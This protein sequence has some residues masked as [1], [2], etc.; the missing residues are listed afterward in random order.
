MS[1]RAL[2]TGTVTFLF[3]DIEGSTR[4]L[5][6][7]GD[8]YRGVQ[9]HHAEIL[10]RAI[11][12]GDGYEVRTEGDAFFVAF[13]NAA[14][15]VR[16]AVA[17][18]RELA[19]HPWPEGVE[20]RV[21]AGLHTG[22]GRL[23][24]DDYIGLDVNRAARIA[25]V[26]HGGQA[27]LSG[28]THALVEHDLPDGV[29]VRDVGRHRLKDLA[30]PEH[31]YELVIEGL[32]SD[33]PPPRSLEARP[34]NL[35][36]QLTSFVGRQREI[37]DVTDRLRRTKLLTLSGP[38]GVG[39]TR[40]ALQVAGEILLE[41]ADGARFVDLSPVTDAA[42][43][44]RAIASAL[45]I[46]EE[47]GRPLADTL[48]DH[49]ADKEM[50]LV[51]DNFE[52]V[53][54]AAGA[55]GDL[56]AAAPRCTFLVTSRAP[57]QL[58]GEQ[59]VSVEPL[60]LPDPARSPDITNLGSESVA[61]FA[62]RSALADPRLRLDAA[63]TLIVGEICS[64]LDGLP[65]AIELAASRVKLLSLEEI[66]E[67]LGT[68]LP[69]LTTAVRD[70]PER[71]RALRTTIDWSYEL[72]AAPER[73]L[74]A[75][76]S[77]FAGG[78]TIESADAVANPSGELGLATLD[79]LSSLVDK[80]LVR[81]SE[82]AG[83]S[84]FGM[85]ETIREYATERLA[86][87]GR[88][89]DVA[90][91]HADYFAELS[92]RAEPEFVGEEQ[93][94]WLDRFEREHENIRAALGWCL[95]SG[96]TEPGLRIAAAIW[97]FWQ[98]RGHLIEGRQWV[99]GLLSL[100]SAAD[101]TLTRGRAVSAAGSLA[102]WQ[103]D[104]PEAERLYQESLTVARTSGDATAVFDASFNLA[105]IPW[106]RGD[107]DESWSLLQ[108][109]LVIARELG[110]ERRIADTASGLAYA[111]FMREDYETALSLNEE[112]IALAREAGNRFILAENIETEGQVHRMLG[113]HERSRAAYLE[114]LELKHEAGNLPGIIT[115]L[116][117]LSVLESGLG[118]HERAVRLFGAASAMRE[119]FA[120]SPPAL[121]LDD[122]RAAARAAIGA[123]AT[124]RAMD[125]GRSMDP[126]AAVACANEP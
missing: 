45:A 37:A 39:K 27:L 2:P 61:L 111:A 18:Q 56:L 73:E 14:G 13:D 59:E 28:P 86:D 110:D 58:Y 113:N 24:G 90:L 119:E 70:R 23:G 124:S 114:A 107:V 103:N 75:R 8:G 48:A 109:C 106:F 5:Q 16:A 10:R 98:Q 65:L 34:H 104:L 42:L 49:L 78:A 3:T 60:S 125:E 64:R 15:S 115:T 102:Y 74:L 121:P 99:A 63:G 83:G 123:E 30:H 29:Q 1:A 116:H 79:G 71:Q 44:P 7:L 77:V 66:R 6:R 105:F 120:A 97:R 91:H 20:L 4:L 93:V 50:L 32:P 72:L 22:E 67:R 76:L 19:G 31:L 55:V 25:A 53:A 88:A 84:R 95:R 47:S 38:G 41:F 92:E 81:R 12:T 68:R 94:A 51:L 57:L 89:D 80:S 117:M 40:L 26:A 108:E 21:R 69:L 36:I 118:R 52:Q 9:D 46:R 35:P 43:V 17:A 82:L 87:G 122:P 54:E 62:E 126:D 100:P 33:F 96:R 101:P 112:A 11:A 85:L